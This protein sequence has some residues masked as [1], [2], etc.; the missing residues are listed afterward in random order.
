MLVLIFQ[1]AIYGA[2]FGKKK[3]DSLLNAWIGHTR[4]NKANT[5][6]GPYDR[7]VHMHA[8]ISVTNL[9]T[10]IIT[11]NILVY[12]ADPAVTSGITNEIKYGIIRYIPVRYKLGYRLNRITPITIHEIRRNERKENWA[13]YETGN[14]GK[15][16]IG[17]MSNYLDE[18]FHH[19]V[20]RYE[21]ENA[22]AQNKKFDEIYW[23]ITGQSWTMSIGS[24]SAKVVLP[25]T[26]LSYRIYSGS[27]GDTSSGAAEIRR[28]SDS[29]IFIRHLNPLNPGNGITIAASFT[30]G[31]IYSPQLYDKIKWIFIANKYVFV[32]PSVALI[33]FILGFLFW[34]FKGRETRASVNFPRFDP[35]DGYSPAEL[36]FLYEQDHHVRHTVAALTDL[37]VKGIIDIRVSKE[38][39]LFPKTLY[40]IVPDENAEFEG[41][42]YFRFLNET[43]M[44]KES[45]VRKGEYSSALASYDSYVK[46]FSQNK[47]V[48]S[49]SYGNVWIQ[50]NHKLLVPGN[51]A[52]G[53][54]FV[55]SFW[56]FVKEPLPNPW[57]VLYAGA[58]MLSGFAFQALWYRLMPNYGKAGSELLSE[59]QGFRLYLV[60]AEEKEMDLMNAPEKSPDLYY[61]YLPFAIALNCELEWSEKFS[62]VL[63]KAVVTDIHTMKFSLSSSSGSSFGA[64]SAAV[65]SAASP[66]SSGSGGS[67][68]SGGSTG[69]G[70]G[71]GGGSGW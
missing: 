46:K 31:M 15:I 52:M 43:G 23:N 35:P 26:L 54:A 29:V 30:A 36:G 38:P 12:N 24:V 28:L 50:L 62:E 53:L 58:G 37:A 45:V 10:I 19:Y 41:I 39:G 2:G 34:Y 49:T 14:S 7:I 60:M 4:Y 63:S 56:W 71:G 13:L 18:G 17:S 40:H 55:I 27:Q 68:F 20:L 66:P 59:I 61:R 5:E 25:A 42:S 9:R 16:V 11:E 67:S 51:I 44:P 47:F 8:E 69:G 1:N 21:M 22:L 64:F 6:P 48:K 70:A 65:S 33:I 3:A 57:G 32:F